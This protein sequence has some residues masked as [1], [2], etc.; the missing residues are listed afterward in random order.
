MVGQQVKLRD[1]KPGMVLDRDG[2]RMAVA[3]VAGGDHYYLTWEDGA[4][5]IPLPGSTVFYI[6][7]AQLSLAGAGGTPS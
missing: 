4:T 5:W 2:Q 7:G 6:V 3:H 1:V